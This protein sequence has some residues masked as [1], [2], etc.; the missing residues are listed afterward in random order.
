MNTQREYMRH[1]THNEV[2]VH[3]TCWLFFN[4]FAPIIGPH[5]TYMLRYLIPIE[6]RKVFQ[7]LY[8]NAN[9]S[10]VRQLN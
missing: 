2:D 3:I 10:A 8:V 4:V 9:A 1:K 7:M 6:M 5:S